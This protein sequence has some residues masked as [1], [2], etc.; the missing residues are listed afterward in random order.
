MIKECKRYFERIEA[1]GGV[2]NGIRTG[3]FQREL[4]RSAYEYQQAVER[5]DEV[6][7]GVNKF[8]EED[9]QLEIPILKIGRESEVAQVQAVREV[10]KRRDSEAVEAALES[11]R[12][13]AQ[14]GENLMPYLLK[15]VKVYATLGEICDA[16]RKVYGEYREP[17]IL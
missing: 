2:L 4:A 3:F 1:E 12:K 14:E 16:L 6:I 7:V 15:A 5:G 9:E 11:V 17:V 8:V 13:A 10:R